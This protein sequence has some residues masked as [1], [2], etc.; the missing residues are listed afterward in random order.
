MSDELEVVE[1]VEAPAPSPLDYEGSR[2]NA[3]VVNEFKAALEASQ[4]KVEEAKPEPTAIEKRAMEQGWRPEHEFDKS[5]GRR[6]IGAEEFLERGELFG[7]IESQK[8]EINQL[9]KVVKEFG[10]HLQ[11]S[12]AATYQNTLMDLD[13]QRQEA[14]KVGNHAKFVAAEQ[15]ML[16]E[17]QRL[18]Q[19]A[20]A[21]V[22]EA[23][24]APPPVSPEA[25]AFVERNKRWFNMNP[26]NAD[27]IEIASQ[28]EEYFKATNPGA[29]ESDI[30]AF[31]ERE[32]HRYFPEL[33]NK[34]RYEPAPVATK[35]QSVGGNKTNLSS[36]FSPQQKQMAAELVKMGAFK[37]SEDYAKQL[38]L[39]GVLPRE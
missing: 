24:V 6:F 7:K 12:Q 25:N 9:K 34:K 10:E 8:S 39:Q 15:Q 3:D 16:A 17:Q 22:Q 33:E 18:Q 1:V 11:K 30:F 35:T 19:M 21:P 29:R 31:V 28:A 13:R 38:E 2:D 14:V 27:K 23:P 20:F 4:P 26:E 36:R 5:K 37:S 32:V